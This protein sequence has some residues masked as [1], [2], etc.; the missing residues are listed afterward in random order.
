MEQTKIILP[1]T[2]D[3]FIKIPDMVKCVI[4]LDI[5]GVLNS[6]EFFERT[7]EV[8]FVNSKLDL[9][10]IGRLNS[11]VHPGIYWVLSSS[12]RYDTTAAQ[13]TQYLVDRGWK[14]LISDTTPIWSG[15][16]RG[17]TIKKWCDE[18]SWDG[19]MIIIDDDHDLEPYAGGRIIYTTMQKGFT[20]DCVERGQRLLKKN[21]VIE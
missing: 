1:R 3:T 4:F 8:D 12:W 20:D 19:P 7:E 14:G 16:R 5:D 21:G 10:A 15:D 11:L 18:H 6:T 2:D 9:D 13:M 17:Y